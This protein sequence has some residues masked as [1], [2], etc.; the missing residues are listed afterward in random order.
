MNLSRIFIERPVMTALISFAILLFGAI[1]FRE[2]PVAALPS[3]DYPTIQVAAA[4]PG[5]SPETMAST[6]ATPLEREFSTIAG[7]QSMDSTNSLGSTSITVQFTLDRKIDAAAQ[8]IQA[9]ISR[10]GGRLP[11][12]MP[13]P[14]SYNKVNPAE[15]PVFYL[16]LDSSTLPMYT[17]NEYADTLLAQ[18][19]SMV[20]GVSRVQVFGAQ[21]YAVRVQ[22]DPT[23]SPPATSASMKCS[24]RSPPAIPTCPPG[25]STATSRRSPSNP[26]ARWAAL[27]RTV[28]SSLPGATA[29]PSASKNSAM[30]LI[31]WTTTR[32][33]PGTT[34]N[35][36]S[37][38]RFSGSPA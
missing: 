24:A 4:L 37:F 25:A 10:A 13:R 8:D 27:P 36:P 18:R 15:Q 26:A 5:A 9:A 17:V 31:A 34:T 19:I 2:L 14:P 21:K 11:P 20:S 35:A 29:P 22:V 23:S 33:L 12:S 28:P 38:S 7:I 30:S 32:S 1:A 16:A 3:V 6:V